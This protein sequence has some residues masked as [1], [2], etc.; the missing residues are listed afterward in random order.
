MEATR[1]VR[2]RI[3]GR[4]YEELV[5]LALSGITT[6][7]LL[8]FSMVRTATGQWLHVAVDLGTLALAVF[9]WL[10]VWRTGR[11]AVAAPLWGIALIA[12]LVGTVETFGAR[13]LFWAYPLMAAAFFL[14]RP[15]WALG[16][17]VAA[18]VAVAPQALA[19]GTELALLGLYPSL[20]A[21]SL[22]AL[23]IVF[24]LERNRAELRSIAE[25]D[26]LT[27]LANRYMLDQ[28]LSHRIAR[29]DSDQSVG[30]LM[31]DLDNFKVVN[32]TMGHSIGDE[33]LREVG[34]RLRGCVAANDVVARFGGDEFVIVVRVDEPARIAR[35][36]D[37][38]QAAMAPAYEAGSSRVDLRVTIGIA[39]YPDH[40]ASAD[41][42]VQ[43]ADTAMYTAKRAGKDRHAFFDAAMNEELQQHLRIEAELRTAVERDQLRLYFQPRLDLDSG[44]IVGA[45]G[46]VRWA[47]PERG[48]LAPC[49]FLAVAEQSSLIDDIDRYV[50]RMTAQQA[51]AWR[52]AG[53]TLTVSVNLSARE[54]HSAGFGRKVARVLAEA[55]ADPSDIEIEI[56]ET[57][58]LRDF[59]SAVEQLDEMRRCAPGLSI[60]LDDFG[61]G[62]SSLQYLRR[63]PIDA[64]KIDR[65]FV[66]DLSDD[67]GGGKAREIAGS[68]V[69]LGHQLALRIVAE[70][71]ETGEQAEILQALGCEEAQGFRFARPMPRDDFAAFL[72]S[73]SAAEG[74]D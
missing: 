44:A 3:S 42:L 1:Q 64:L 65:S 18:G 72:S 50:L 34:R 58:V 55:G 14:M 37:R 23:S 73:M 6:V 32:D 70:G 28:K 63:L 30:V 20:A 33:L 29:A 13:M 24:A 5:V 26:A 25:R 47:H 31:L 38:V 35:L 68:I 67:Q 46:L 4:S 52:R 61:T 48:V 2:D 9:V 10:Y 69:Q 56:T 39:L 66:A 19:F 59:A 57:V 22:L 49:E 43:A 54:L 36:I 27:G 12:L 40:G 15:S 45:E 60:A 71:V 53:W 74:S 51:A 17:N 16:L 41:A 11:T 21:T 7:F 62:Y 8:T